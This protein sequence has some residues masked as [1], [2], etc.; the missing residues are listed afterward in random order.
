MWCVTGQQQSFQQQARLTALRPT[1]THTAQLHLFTWLR[2]LHYLYVITMFYIFIEYTINT[3]KHLSVFHLCWW[4]FSL[5]SIPCSKQLDLSIVVYSIIV[6]GLAQ[7]DS[8]ERPHIWS[9]TCGVACWQICRYMKWL[10][11]SAFHLAPGRIGRWL[12][13]LKRGV[14]SPWQGTYIWISTFIL[15]TLLAVP[16]LFCYQGYCIILSG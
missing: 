8:L 2:T 15:F 7:R 1:Y 10:S 9:A 6:T 11:S 12:S 5:I 4:T 3:Y 16:L 14:C 13:P